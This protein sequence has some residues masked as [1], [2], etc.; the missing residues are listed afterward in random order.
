MTTLTW[1]DV[2]AQLSAGRAR[3]ITRWE[4][5]KFASGRTTSRDVAQLALDEIDRR[6]A[7]GG[8]AMA[9]L[10]QDTIFVGERPVATDLAA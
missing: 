1:P 10:Y 4:L 3:E 6:D 7:R 5:E 2:L 9:V 8:S